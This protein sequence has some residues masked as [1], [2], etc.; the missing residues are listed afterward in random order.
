MREVWGQDKSGQ[1]KAMK[2]HLVVR[3][4]VADVA[5]LRAEDRPTAPAVLPA[6]TDW[7]MLPREVRCEALSNVASSDR[8]ADPW[9]EPG[10][11]LPASRWPGARFVW[12]GQPMV[13][14]W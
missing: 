4:E 1:R 11:R 10:L 12:M 13:K 7:D 6:V 2:P 5:V 3:H 8:V 9:R 14:Q